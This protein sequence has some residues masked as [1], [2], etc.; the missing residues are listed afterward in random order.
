[1]LSSTT[2]IRS[3]EFLRGRVLQPGRHIFIHGDRG[4]GKTSL[5]QTAAI[6]N[7]TSGAQPIFMILLEGSGGGKSA[8]IATGLLTTAP[9]Y[10]GPALVNDRSV[11]P[12][13]AA[14]EGD[15]TLVLRPDTIYMVRPRDTS[16]K[17]R[18]IS[19]EIISNVSSIQKAHL[20]ARHNPAGAIHPPSAILPADRLNRVEGSAV[21]DS[22]D[23]SRRLFA[24]AD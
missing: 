9:V 20:T 19:H 16:R 13:C 18:T 1:M 17:Y 2:P 23:F 8:I 4:V 10:C 15:T 11:L 21:T 14:L 22:Q 7:Q 12:E 5:A 6:E 24:A 3:S